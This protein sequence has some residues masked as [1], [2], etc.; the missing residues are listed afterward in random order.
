MKG[1][2]VITRTNWNGIEIEIRWNLDQLTY[3]DLT[4]MA[5]LEVESISLR[6]RTLGLFAQGHAAK[7][8]LNP[9]ARRS[10]V[11]SNQALQKL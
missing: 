4:H 9:S 10:V 3:D 2:Y 7:H 8:A 11:S 6:E 1:T 5:H